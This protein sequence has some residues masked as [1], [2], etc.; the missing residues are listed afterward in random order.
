M[1]GT[2]ASSINPQ[3]LIQW[4]RFPFLTTLTSV[5]VFPWLAIK[6]FCSVKLQI[7]CVLKRG[8]LGEYKDTDFQRPF[9]QLPFPTTHR[10]RADA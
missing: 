6:Y 3:G 5:V 9:P 4:P 8:I 10:P 2:K 1:V 7:A